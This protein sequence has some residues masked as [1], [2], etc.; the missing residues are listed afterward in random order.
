MSEHPALSSVRT[1]IVGELKKILPAENSE[2]R[3]D[4][5]GV[6]FQE[7]TGTTQS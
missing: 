7:W 3:S 2:I 1:W 6:V 4:T 5:N